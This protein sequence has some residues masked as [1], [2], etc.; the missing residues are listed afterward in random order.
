VFVYI[1]NVD[2]VLYLAWGNVPCCCKEISPGFA[3]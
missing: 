2:G 3:R 1:V